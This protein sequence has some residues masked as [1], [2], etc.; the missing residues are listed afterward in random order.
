MNTGFYLAAFA[1]LALAAQP[2]A[3]E[4]A[5]GNSVLAFQERHA[6]EMRATVGITIPFGGQRNQAASQ[7]RLDLG[8]DHRTEPHDTLLPLNPVR[9]FEQPE[10]RGTSFAVTFE[11]APRLMLNGA[12]FAQFNTRLNADETEEEGGTDAD[13]GP[14][15][16]L[17]L[18]GVLVGGILAISVAGTADLVDAVE[19]LSDPD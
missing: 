19:D 12:Q 6:S 11:R 16:A 17:I 14:N 3:A 5:G 8:F 9:N 18:G 4:S 7:P 15:T 1:A 13:S 2:A 10:W